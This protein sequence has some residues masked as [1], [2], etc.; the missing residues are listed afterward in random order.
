MAEEVEKKTDDCGGGVA[1]KTS[2]E[3]FDKWSLAVCQLWYRLTQ[4]ETE[5]GVS[6]AIR[7][8]NKRETVP[9]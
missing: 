4:A 7:Q 8:N 3:L 2:V 5:T 1:N 9:R 6:L